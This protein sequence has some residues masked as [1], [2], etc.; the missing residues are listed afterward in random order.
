MTILITGAAGYIGTHICVEI[1]NRGD[2]IVLIDNLSNS[3]IDSLERVANITNKKF[4]IAKKGSNFL[5]LIHDEMIFI[6]E[7]IRNSSILNEIFYSFDISAVIHLAGYKSVGESLLNPLGYYENNLIGSITLFQ[8]MKRAKV[9]NLIFSSTA[10]VYGNPESLPIKE[11]FYADGGTNPYGQSKIF[12]EKI[13]KDL[14]IADP[15]WKITILRY[16]NPVGAHYSGLIGEDLKDNPS[17]LMPFIS[18]VASGRFKKLRIFGNDYPTR[19]GTGIRDYIHVMDL[20][21]G[22]LSALDHLFK[23][24]PN[25]YVFNLG[26]GS[27][28]SILELVH[29]FEEVTGKIIPYEFVDKRIGDIA[30]SWTSIELAENELGWTSKYSLK[31]MC[32]DTWRWQLKN[33]EG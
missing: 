4:T 17:N 3:K 6:N 18:Q 33:L 29:A 26:T 21:K 15:T 20:A 11:N 23:A 1:L 19:D 32:E 24:Q 22:H 10:S 28:T 2:Q 14:H 31:K 9:K 13:L 25:T 7:D 12:I 30:E 27:G 8:E 16:F 5:S